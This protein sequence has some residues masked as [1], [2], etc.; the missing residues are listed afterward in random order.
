MIGGYHMQILKSTEGW[1]IAVGLVLVLLSLIYV[2]GWR[3]LR[4][5]Q[6]HLATRVRLALFG[7]SLVAVA[8]VMISPLESWSR[9]LLAA[10][11]LQ[12]ILLCMI[13]APIFWLSCPFH[14]SMWGVP[15][16][17]RRRVTKFLH[18]GSPLGRLL[19]SATQPGLTWLLFLSA[20][21]SWH[22]PTFVNYIMPHP[23]WHRIALSVLFGAALL[24]WWHIVETGPRIHGK[25]P[26]WVRFACLI[27][28]EIPNIASGLTIAFQ[29]VPLYTYYATMNAMLQNP[30]HLTMLD[31]QRLSGGMIWVFG[32]LAY[33]SSA[34]MVLN[35]IFQENNGNSPQPMPNWDADDRM[36][37]PGLE[38]RVIE[39]RWRD[40]ELP[41]K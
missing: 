12:K 8:I 4:I 29:T 28:V 2:R 19:R 6:P 21:L 1:R 20:F 41:R 34:V 33:F 22:D 3:R 31:D 36:I 11:S 25:Y 27:G 7:I 23:W 37:A 14:C 9:Y 35:K 24:F 40:I 17:L 10:R 38:H 13:A 30:L 32:S 18:Q 16:G 26:D 15:V 5:I 39:N